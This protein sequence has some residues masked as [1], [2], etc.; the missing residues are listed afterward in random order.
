MPL[1]FSFPFTEKRKDRGILSISEISFSGEGTYSPRKITVT[2]ELRFDAVL[3][4]SR[5][6][7]PIE[8]SFTI[9]IEESFVWKGEGV[10]S[11]ADLDE[12]VHLYEGDEIDLIPPLEEW[13][14]LTLPLYPL[15]KSDCKG[16]CPVC[17]TN[18]NEKECGCNQEKIDPR[19]AGLAKFF[20]Q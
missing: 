18:R 19:L 14:Y 10:Q 1:R 5:C 17:G 16:L 4:C 7:T 15:C 12:G 8:Q 6:L 13:V 2:G 20:E 3:S 9:P 11:E